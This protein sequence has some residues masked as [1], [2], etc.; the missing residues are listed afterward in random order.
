MQQL[1]Q[2]RRAQECQFQAAVDRIEASR[3]AV[4]FQYTSI[5]NIIDSSFHELHEMLDC[6]KQHLLDITSDLLKKSFLGLTTREKN[7]RAV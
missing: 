2:F 6:R 4:K 7:L 5:V 1:D 3:L